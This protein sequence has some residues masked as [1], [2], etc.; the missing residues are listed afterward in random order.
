LPHDQVDRISVAS[1]LFRLLIK[2]LQVATD[3]LRRLDDNGFGPEWQGDLLQL[4]L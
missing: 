4:K 1:F 2:R 3:A